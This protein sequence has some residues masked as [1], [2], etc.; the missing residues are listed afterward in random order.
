M[1]AGGDD[2]ASGPTAEVDKHY[3]KLHCD[4]KPVEKKSE[5]YKQ[6]QK[7]VTHGARKSSPLKS[8]LCLSLG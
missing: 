5:A 7:Y 2:G 1:L 6:L 4:L 3:A 8:D